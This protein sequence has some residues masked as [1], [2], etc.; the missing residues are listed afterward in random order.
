MITIVQS[1]KLSKLLLRLHCMVNISVHELQ[2]KI[3]CFELRNSFRFQNFIITAQGQKPYKHLDHKCGIY[4]RQVQ[5][6]NLL[7]P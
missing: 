7:T 3:T 1:L 2:R 4:K 5:L 6:H